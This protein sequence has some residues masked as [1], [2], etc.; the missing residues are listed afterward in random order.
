MKLVEL[1]G[2]A[3]P[4]E[5]AKLMDLVELSEQVEPE[6]LA[7]LVERTETTDRNIRVCDCPVNRSNKT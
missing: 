2:L 1:A 3:E 6:E 5:L 7:E 4:S